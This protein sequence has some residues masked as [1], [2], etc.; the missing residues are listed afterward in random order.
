[1]RMQSTLTRWR[2]AA[3]CEVFLSQCQVAMWRPSS[4]EVRVMSLVS[5]IKTVVSLFMTAF[6][7]YT[8]H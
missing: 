8:P 5:L 6:F 7:T 3:R 2:R 4:G 1:M